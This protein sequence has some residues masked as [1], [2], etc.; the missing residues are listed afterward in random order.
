MSGISPPSIYSKPPLILVVDD[1][2]TMRL[3]L[4]Q[5]LEKEG[6]RV[7]E[8]TNGKQCLDAYADEKPDL[9]LLDAVMP[10]MDGFTCC[11]E[12]FKIA[13]N[14]LALALAAF[15]NESSFD[16]NVISK[17]WDRTP[18]LMITGLDDP[19]SVDRAFLAGASDYIT[20]PIH[21]TVLRH[22]VRRLLQQGQLYKQLEAANEA[23]QQLANIDALTGLANRRR[24][25][26]YLNFQW[27]S[28]AQQ[29]APVS[30]ILCDIDCFKLYNDKYGHPAGD[31]CLQ[32]VA[33]VLKEKVQ[34]IHDLVARYGGEEFAVIMP[35]TRTDG[36]MQVAAAIQA[37]VREL[38]IAHAA[39]F[40]S[41]YV[42]M[43]L[44]I[45]S[46]IPSLESSPTALV[47]AADEALYQ[48]KALGRNQIS[49]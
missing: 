39:S 46:T 42:T 25:D 48:A 15:E 9:I 18:I 16:N 33:A 19:A 30:L 13:K 44:G 22:R 2:R 12:L 4:R 23:L 43:S 17:L 34:N 45:A 35:H 21:W 1:D 28:L 3:L 36:A 38:E 49:F 5:A 8:L 32:K 29:E 27:F 14:N 31:L 37:G 26:Q 47:V 20:K 7:V 40:V 24:F 11:Q 10:V 6:Y 41:Q